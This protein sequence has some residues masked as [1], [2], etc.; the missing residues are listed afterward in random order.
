MKI[1]ENDVDLTAYLA[2]NELCSNE[3]DAGVKEDLI[4][5]MSIHARKIKEANPNFVIRI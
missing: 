4:S 5:K 1:T 2:L 3:T